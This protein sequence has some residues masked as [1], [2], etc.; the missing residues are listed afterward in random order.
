MPDRSEGDWSFWRDK[1]D[2]TRSDLIWNSYLDYDEL[3]KLLNPET[4]FVQNAN[5]VPWTATY[6][7]LFDSKEYSASMSPQLEEYPTSFRA[8]RAINLIKD[9]ESVTFEELVTTS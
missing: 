3:P 5:D 4:G 8:Q 6:P 1:V 9:D 2:G 7:L